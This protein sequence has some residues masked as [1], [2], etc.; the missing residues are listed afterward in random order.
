MGGVVSGRGGEGLL[1]RLS[2]FVAN[3]MDGNM[4][5]YKRVILVTPLS[6]QFY[7]KKSYLDSK[8]YRSY[9]EPQEGAGRIICWI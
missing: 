7:S 9:G 8:D 4:V 1:G 5:A 6:Y 3:I 2:D